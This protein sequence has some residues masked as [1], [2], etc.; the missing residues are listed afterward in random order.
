MTGKYNTF[1]VSGKDS[2][3]I[4]NLSKM[5]NLSSVDI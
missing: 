3:V 2:M 4:A 5:D 1:D